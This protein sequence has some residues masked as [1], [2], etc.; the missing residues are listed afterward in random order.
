MVVAAPV[1]AQFVSAGMYGPPAAPGG[2]PYGAPA[3]GLY[4]AP[5]P[6]IP[7]EV[8]G[9]A[10]VNPAFHPHE[11][12]HA[13]RYKAMYGPFYHKVN[14]HWIMTPFGIWSKENWKLQGTT[15]DVQY[16][17]RISPFALFCPPI[18]R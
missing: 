6:G 13:H 15:V 12:M 18:H 11:M 10:I 1:P 4:P 16:K 3:G 17:S 7:A 8:G 9:T 2:Q 5:K 14:G